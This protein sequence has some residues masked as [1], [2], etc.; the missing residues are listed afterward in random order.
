MSLAFIHSTN[1]SHL[2]LKND[3]NLGAIDQLFITKSDRMKDWND[4]CAKTRIYS[5]HG[6][7]LKDGIGTN[8]YVCLKCNLSFESLPEVEKHFPQFIRSN[9]KS[10]NKRI[11][12]TVLRKL[13]KYQ[14]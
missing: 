7:R 9:D 10:Y 6:I 3:Q 13:A 1:K 5:E 14:I 4:V 8:A 12:Q 2:K 11:S